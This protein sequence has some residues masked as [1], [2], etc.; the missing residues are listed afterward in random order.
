MTVPFHLAIP[1]ADLGAA[2]AFYVD[3]LGCREGRRGATW[4]DF[5]FFG[6]QLVVHVIDRPDDRAC[7][8]VEVGQN[9][10][11]GHAVPLPHFGAVLSMVAWRELADRLSNAGVTF[12]LPP[13]QRY[14]GQVNEQTSM[15]L[16]DPSGNAI[17]FKA[18]SDPNKL[19]AA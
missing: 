10:I 6:H 14:Q 2:R 17:E 15:V 19:F 8:L 4:A 3:L 7:C 9:T 18:F 12:V 5:D 13:H 11:D 1:V 16:R